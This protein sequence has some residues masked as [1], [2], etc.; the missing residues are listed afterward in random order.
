MGQWGPRPQLGDLFA[1]R[2]LGSR[3]GHWRY[4]V[5]HGND[6]ADASSRVRQISFTTGGV[7]Q[8]QRE[9]LRSYADAWTSIVAAGRTPAP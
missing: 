3:Y 4:N 1:R 6:R 9:K 2:L 7:S 5:S 8:A